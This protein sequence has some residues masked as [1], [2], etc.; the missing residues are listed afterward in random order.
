MQVM[1]CFNRLHKGEGLGGGILFPFVLLTHDA[2]FHIEWSL[3]GSEY[4]I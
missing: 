1:I 4:Q 3:H 2:L